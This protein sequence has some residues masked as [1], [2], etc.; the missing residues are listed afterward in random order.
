MENR[1]VVLANMH[2]FSVVA[3]HLSFTKAAVEL[4]LSQGAVSYRIKML[5]QQLGFPVFI[6]LTRKLE[7]TNEGQR[8][9]QTLNPS[10]DR[11]FSELEDIRFNQLSGDLT[12]GTSPG[13][14]MDWLL[15]RLARFQSLYPQLN[16]TIISKEYR[17]D[18]E[19]ESIDLA[20]YYSR[21]IYPGFYAERLFEEQFLPVMSPQYAEQFNL[22]KGDLDSLA[23]VNFIQIIDSQIW[24]RWLSEMGKNINPEQQCYR[25]SQRGQDLLAAKHHLGVAMGR[26]HAVAPQ[27]QRAELIA[28]YPAIAGEGGYDLVCPQGMELQARFQAFAKWLRHEIISSR[29]G[30]S[31]LPNAH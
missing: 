17:Y 11:I 20:I 9:L 18:F 4:C 14:A 22:L 27:L 13:F 29:D 28:P 1:Q 8:L 15:P 6:R 31:K 19:Q 3:K 5:E 10:F 26:L 2:T 30:V 16:V 24:A 23:K 25:L 12:I 7:L 21:G